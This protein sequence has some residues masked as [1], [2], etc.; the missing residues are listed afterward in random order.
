MSNPFAPLAA[1]AALGHNGQQVDRPNRTGKGRSGGG[2]VA[3]ALRGAG[4]VDEDSG[5]RDAG[6]TGPRRGG[7]GVDTRG[8][9]ARS[10][11]SLS[12]SFKLRKI[13][14]AYQSRRLNILHPG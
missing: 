11:N 13:S 2:L 12:V 1:G 8:D 14:D 10:S 5:M 4:L 6:S 7:R 9:A 3:G